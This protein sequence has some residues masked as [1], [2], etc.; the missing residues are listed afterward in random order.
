MQ[1]PAE[2]NGIIPPPPPASATNAPRV[3]REGNPIEEPT[4]SLNTPRASSE[5]A[6][7]NDDGPSATPKEGELDETPTGVSIRKGRSK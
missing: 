4:S 5:S 2:N 1:I 3:D 7:G 6:N